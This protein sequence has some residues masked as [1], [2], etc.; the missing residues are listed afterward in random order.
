MATLAVGA[1][2]VSA[3]EVEGD[4]EY[5]QY[6]AAECTSC[7]TG[8]HTDSGIPNISGLSADGML[9]MLRAYKNKELENPTMQTIAARL[10]EEQM[11]AL[12]AYYATLTPDQ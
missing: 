5:G 10:D 3:E 6:L 11:A 7:H 1:V 8:N 2:T 12:A 4:V 9:L